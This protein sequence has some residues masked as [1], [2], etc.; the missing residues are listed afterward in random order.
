MIME[1]IIILI[2]SLFSIG[3]G[4]GKNG[5]TTT[6]LE[7]TLDNQDINNPLPPSTIET[8]VLV[9]TT[10]EFL[11]VQIYSELEGDD[12]KASYSFW[13]TF[14]FY[15]SEL[16]EGTTITAVSGALS[17]DQ[18]NDGDYSSESIYAESSSIF[19]NELCATV[20]SCR[21]S[22][23]FKITLED[24]RG[25]IEG[26]FS[27]DEVTS[28][29][30]PVEDECEE[31][32]IDPSLTTEISGTLD[33]NDIGV[34]EPNTTTANGVTGS[35]DGFDIWVSSNTEEGIDEEDF[36]DFDISMTFNNPDE[37][38]EGTLY[39]IENGDF[40]AQ[41]FGDVENDGDFDKE[42]LGFFES[43]NITFSEVCTTSGSHLNVGTFELT[44]EDS[45]GSIQGQFVAEEVTFSN[46]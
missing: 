11:F 34:F 14:T 10:D 15:K 37:L 42:H 41:F 1:K 43:G 45:R 46:Q 36:Y 13:I 2:I 22:G 18:A 6:E 33:G 16:I 23:T 9:D 12:E 38:E 21:N 24:S 40:Y 26:Q 32:E 8:R 29:K 31:N 39:T 17:I 20:G 7:G 27:A 3:F 25:N 28:V 4:C 19:F 44:F 30:I 35:L 5:I